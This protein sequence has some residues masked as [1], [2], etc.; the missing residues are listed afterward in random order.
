MDQDKLVFA[1]RTTDDNGHSMPPKN[2]PND[3]DG[4]ALR[5]LQSDGSDLS[6]PM[7]IDFAVSVPSAV[8][9]NA[10]AQRAEPLGFI[11]DVDYDAETEAWT[12]YCTKVVIPEYQPIL[13]IQESLL[14]CNSTSTHLFQ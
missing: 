9:G 13:G 12:C 10:V 1:N 3:A 8:I 11:T 14:S 6:K 4:D 5:Q 2:V 7:K